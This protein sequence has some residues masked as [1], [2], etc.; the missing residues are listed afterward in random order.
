MRDLIKTGITECFQVFVTGDDVRKPKP[1][2][3]S[4]HA[5]L[6]K[7]GVPSNEAL[8]VGDARADYEIARVADVAFLGVASKF[9]GS[10]SDDGYQRVD[11][12]SNV[13]KVLL[14]E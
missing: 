6:E 2:P 5:E 9:S 3:E 8:Y 1:S 10:T 4:L 13:I 12:T 14:R 7:L 11:P